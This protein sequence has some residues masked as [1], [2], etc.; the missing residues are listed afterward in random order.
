ML[1]SICTVKVF[2]CNKKT[3]NHISTICKYRLNYLIF[4]YL[5]E[6]KYRLAIIII[7]AKSDPAF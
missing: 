1:F 7:I 2:F 4:A 5:I 3:Y 6:Q